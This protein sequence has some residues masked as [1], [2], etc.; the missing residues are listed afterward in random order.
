MSFTRKWEEMEI[1]LSK[2]REAQKDKYVCFSS[3][4][5][6]RLTIRL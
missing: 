4:A 5:K 3:N 1:M 6:S 2:I